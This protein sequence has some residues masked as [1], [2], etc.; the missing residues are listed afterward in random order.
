MPELNNP[1]NVRQSE[2]EELERQL[3]EKK[4]AMSF[5]GNKLENEKH[6]DL[7]G[8]NMPEWQPQSAT[9]TQTPSTSPSTDK[10]TRI[11]HDVKS[12]S[13]MDESHKIEMLVGLALDKGI[14]HSIEVADGLKDPFILDMLHDKLVG[15]LHDRLVKE[16]KL[17][18]V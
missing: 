5:E 16:R 10:T 4:A 11:A 12:I 15:E 13:A 3:A 1:E 2:I 14:A 18:E 9:P 8:E 6:I 17:K 7:T